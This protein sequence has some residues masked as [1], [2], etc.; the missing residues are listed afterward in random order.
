MVLLA[1]VSFIMKFVDYDRRSVLGISDRI[2][3]TGSDLVPPGNVEMMEMME[4][5]DIL[6]DMM[7]LFGI[8][9][10]QYS[11]SIASSCACW[12]S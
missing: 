12:W 9:Q 4:M 7:L 3:R 11:S 2:V 8:Q 1:N 10:Y 6:F 5:M